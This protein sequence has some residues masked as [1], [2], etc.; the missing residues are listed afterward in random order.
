MFTNTRLLVRVSCPR[1][2]HTSETKVPKTRPEFWENLNN[3]S[4]EFESEMENFKDGMIMLRTTFMGWK[5]KWKKP[6]KFRTRRQK[7][8]SSK[9]VDDSLRRQMQQ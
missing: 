6:L 1:K 8:G 3:F 2:H 9:G 7:N 5:S 4:F